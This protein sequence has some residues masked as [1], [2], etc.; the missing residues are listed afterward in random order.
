MKKSELK[1]LIREIISEQGGPGADSSPFS[2]V[3]SP[4]LI[5][6][7][8]PVTQDQWHVKCPSGYEFKSMDH[9]A[10]TFDDVVYAGS[11]NH[12]HIVDQVHHIVDSLCRL[13]YFGIHHCMSYNCYWE[14]SQLNMLIK[15]MF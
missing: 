12:F 11:N 8:G 7:V 15:H 5:G 4:Y 1:K 9:T 14:Y 6:P 10:V 3:V 2:E 13:P